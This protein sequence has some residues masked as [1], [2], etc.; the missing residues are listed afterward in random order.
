MAGVNGVGGG[1]VPVNTTR[2]PEAAAPA[3]NPKQERLDELEDLAKFKGW[4]GLRAD[5]QAELRALRAELHPPSPT[6]QAGAS[7]NAVVEN[8]PDSLRRAASEADKQ[9]KDLS[10]KSTQLVTQ[11]TAAKTEF[12]NAKKAVPFLDHLKWGDSDAVKKRNAA[13][14]NIHALEGQLRDVQGQI[15]QVNEQIS[16]QLATYLHH[17]DADFQALERKREDLESLKGALG[18]VAQKVAAYN[19][20]LNGAAASGGAAVTNAV[21]AQQGPVFGGDQEWN[22]TYK[23][24]NNSAAVGNAVAAGIQGLAAYGDRNAALGAAEGFNKTI[25]E[26]LHSGSKAVTADEKLKHTGDIGGLTGE[27]SALQGTLTSRLDQANRTYNN[28]IM[29]LRKDLAD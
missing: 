23:N 2:Q 8:A 27:V 5:Q 28:M 7:G 19:Q 4:N 10:A 1:N 3:V 13:E 18:G 21:A 29:T 9:I 12:E 24:I 20:H 6:R 11:L 26:L 17:N 22:Q 25:D 15:G 16:G 14:Q